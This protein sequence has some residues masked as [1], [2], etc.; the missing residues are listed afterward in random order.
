M[1]EFPPEKEFCCFYLSPQRLPVGGVLLSLGL[2][3][4]RSGGNRNEGGVG[5]GMEW[6]SSEMELAMLEIE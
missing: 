4:S 5:A 3:G 2:K 6:E 1:P